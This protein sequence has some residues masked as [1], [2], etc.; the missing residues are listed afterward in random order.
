MH[1]VT[2]IAAQN[3]E[4]G[5]CECCQCW[6]F[7]LSECTIYI[8]MTGDFEDNQVIGMRK[9]GTVNHS[10]PWSCRLT[11][12]WASKWTYPFFMVCTLVTHRHKWKEGVIWKGGIYYTTWAFREREM[13]LSSEREEDDLLALYQSCILA[14]RVLCCQTGRTNRVALLTT[15]QICSLPNDKAELTCSRGPHCVVH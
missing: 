6:Q 1:T 15:I 2:F 14:S 12:R 3:W 13:G 8:N 9:Q 4:I 11:R 5:W 10:V 7:D